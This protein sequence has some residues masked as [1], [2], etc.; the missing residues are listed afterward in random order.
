MTDEQYT[1][2]RLAALYDPLELDRPDLDA[3]LAVAEELRAHQIL[4][5]GC[6]TGTLALLLARRGH[7]VTGVDPAGA[8][9][10]VARAKSGADQ[11]RW[12]HGDATGLPDLAVDLALMTGNA[13]QAVVDEDLWAD[14]LRGVRAALRPG[15]WFVFETRDPARRAWEE[16]T[17]E[18]SRRTVRVPGTGEVET[19]FEV[20]GVRWP[21]VTFRTGYVL[22]ATGETLFSESTLR[23][24]ERDEV[25]ATLTASGFTVEE[26]RGAPD[27]PGKE[28]VFFARARAVVSPGGES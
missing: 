16:W 25:A 15:G 26:V 2:P 18:E 22:A 12:L 19:W 3:Y 23:F 7:S 8:S 17:P 10:D 6:G 27:R 9:L 1:D 14:T 5:V 13:A 21:L 20:T 4:D 28:F 11:V 24:R